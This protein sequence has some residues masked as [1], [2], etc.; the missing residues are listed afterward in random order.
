LAVGST[1]S[2]N[3]PGPTGASLLANRARQGHAAVTGYSHA[4]T[5]ISVYIQDM[6]VRIALCLRRNNRSGNDLHKRSAGFLNRHSAFSQSHR[7]RYCETRRER[8]YFEKYSG[9]CWPR[10]HAPTGLARLHCR[11]SQPGPAAELGRRSTM[12]R[13]SK[14]RRGIRW[15]LS[16]L[17]R[18]DIARHPMPRNCFAVQATG[19][20]V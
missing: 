20:F 6:L 12:A 8:T 16:A 7:C 14:K 17:L 5:A 1:I 3:C 15:P 4:G 18:T 10:G 2:S 9:R 11:D 13:I 19:R